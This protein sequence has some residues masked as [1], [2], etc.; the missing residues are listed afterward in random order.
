MKKTLEP[1]QMANK[2]FNRLMRKSLINDED[3]FNNILNTSALNLKEI[4]I[5]Y[6]LN[7]PTISIATNKN[8]NESFKDWAVEEVL[9]NFSATN[10]KNNK[11]KF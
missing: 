5:K 7:E 10:K 11:K 3:I 2:E 9:T 4:V 6:F 1:I 8:I